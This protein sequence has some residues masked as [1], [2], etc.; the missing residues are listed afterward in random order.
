MTYKFDG[1]L[2]PIENGVVNV[3]KAG[4]AIP[5]KWRLT[6]ANDV[7]IHDPGSFTGL[8]S[9]LYACTGGDPTDAVV[10]YAAGSSGRQYN[11]DGYWQFNRKTPKDY[12]NSCRMMYVGFDSGVTSPVVK[13]QFKK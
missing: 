5:V 13:F 10:E 9:S 8:F 2:N 1:F 3:A 6:D 4:Q 7:P 11:G 12:A